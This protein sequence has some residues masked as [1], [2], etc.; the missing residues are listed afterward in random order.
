M[1][2]VILWIIVVIIVGGTAFRI[3]QR[4][5]TKRML[6]E[7][8]SHS[9]PV[10]VGIIKKG[11]IDDIA[12]YSG[13]IEGEVQA[14]IYSEVPGR[15]LRFTVKEG[16]RVSKDE[17]VAVIERSVTGME[18]K[19]AIVKAPISGIVGIFTVDMGDVVIPEKPIGIVGKTQKV[20]ITINVPGKEYPLIKK[21]KKAIIF[22]DAYPDTLFEG[23][24]KKKAKFANPFT[25]AI[26]VDI[27]I[28]NKT[29]MLIPGMFAEVHLIRKTKKNVIVIPLDAVLG[30]LD[31][32]YVY[33]CKDGVAKKV[34][35]NVGIIGNKTIEVKEGLNVG[36][37]LIVVGQKVVMDGDRV[38]VVKKN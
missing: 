8:V 3:I 5:R 18:F 30:R 37:S 16:D 20:R 17:A 36:D 31:D 28:D 7:E 25:A 9:I 22:I 32:R 24:I 19:P 23:N 4:S 12:I 35:V 10:K 6:Q 27:L 29:G 2:K 26:P 11:D 15:L 13:F 1:K 34:E 38:S 33:I 21:A 14:G